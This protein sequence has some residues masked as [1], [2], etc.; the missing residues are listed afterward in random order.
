MQQQ[1]ALYQYLLRWADT[2]LIMGQRLAEWCSRGPIL[3]EDL[4]LTNIA[5]DYFGQAEGFY[6][7]ALLVKPSHL[8][9][10][11]LAFRRSERDYFNYLLPELQNGDFAQTLWKIYFLSVFLEKVYTQLSQSS[12][13][14]L[15]SLAIKSLKEITY[16]K[17]HSCSWLYRLANGTLES[18]SRVQEGL[19]ELWRYTEDL[20]LTNEVDDTLASVTQL[21]MP[22][23]RLAWHQEVIAF[24]SQKCTFELP[25]QTFMIHGGINCSHTEELGHLLTEMQYLQRAYPDAQW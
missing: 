20:F 8:T 18:A 21:D 5:L 13:E 6:Q 2:S 10:D 12:E 23:I 9:A 7:H 24:I 17:R 14:K 11:D 25:Q 4:A 22:S 1:D 16:H 15:S 19:H 3:E